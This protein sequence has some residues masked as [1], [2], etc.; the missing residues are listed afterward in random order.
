M[1]FVTQI[2]R[3][4][5]VF[6]ILRRAQKVMPRNNSKKYYPDLFPRF[7]FGCRGDQRT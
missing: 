4:Q 3:G 1:P 5:S 7:I 6:Q 2:E